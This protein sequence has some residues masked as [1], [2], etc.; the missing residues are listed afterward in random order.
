MGTTNMRNGTELLTGKCCMVSICKDAGPGEEAV[1]RFSRLG[2]KAAG[3]IV[4]G[5]IL[6]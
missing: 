1:V 2:E 6:L 3:M 4:S 5:P